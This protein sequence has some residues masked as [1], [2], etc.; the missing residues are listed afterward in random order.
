VP[1]PLPIPLPF[2]HIFQGSCIGSAQASRQNGLHTSGK[3]LQMLIA[4]EHSCLH[5]IRA[6]NIL[7][8]QVQLLE[9]HRSWC[10]C[11]CNSVLLL[12]LDVDACRRE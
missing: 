3:I 9:C 8:C 7:S 6:T 1:Q 11:Q 10:S 12:I 4:C 2:P 5:K